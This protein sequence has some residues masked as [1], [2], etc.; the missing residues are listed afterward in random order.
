MRIG[1]SLS[2]LVKRNTRLQINTKLLIIM[3]SIAEKIYENPIL[4]E[5]G[6]RILWSNQYYTCYVFADGSRLAIGP[7][8]HESLLRFGY[9]HSIMFAESLKGHWLAIASI[10]R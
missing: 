8:R 10:A 2:H 9:T 4:L 6:N 3:N 7:M 5:E 1:V